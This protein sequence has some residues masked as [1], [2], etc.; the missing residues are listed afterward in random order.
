MGPMARQ[1]Y[2]AAP[3]GPSWASG[4]CPLT[5]CAGGLLSGENFRGIF[6][7]FNLFPKDP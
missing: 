1:G 4:F 7:R 6:P 5:P 3:W 2:H